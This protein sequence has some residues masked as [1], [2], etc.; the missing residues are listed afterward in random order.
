MKWLQS[1]WGSRIL[2]GIVLAQC[3]AMYAWWLMERDA[4][5]TSIVA[6]MVDTSREEFDRC[7]HQVTVGDVDGDGEVNWH[8]AYVHD[9]CERCPECCVDTSK[10]PQDDVPSGIDRIAEDMFCTP[11][12][13]P[14]RCCPCVRGIQGLWWI[15]ETYF[16]TDDDTECDPK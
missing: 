6:C 13:C 2:L 10:P 11:D 15:D 7:S 12:V 4:V 9:H 14:G 5:M 16:G 8:D 1:K 3:V